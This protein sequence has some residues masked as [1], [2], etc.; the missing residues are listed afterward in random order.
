MLVAVER[1]ADR[2]GPLLLAFEDLHWMDASTRLGVARLCRDLL[3]VPVVL[4]ATYRSDAVPTDGGLLELLA[5]LDRLP[6]VERLELGPLSEAEVHA[7]LV[8]IMGA[9]AS[10]PLLRSIVDRADGNPFF[11]EELALAAS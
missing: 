1:V 10:A 6:G 2:H 9:D 8:G 11:V 4:A 5:E 7:Q 3:G